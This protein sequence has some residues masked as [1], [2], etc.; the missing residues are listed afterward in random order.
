M[1]D[2]E[3]GTVMGNNQAATT[4]PGEFMGAVNAYTP[5]SLA[6]WGSSVWHRWTAPSTGDWKFSVDRRGLAVSVF[7]GESVEDARLV[8]GAPATRFPDSALFPATRGVEYYI[9]VA[10][11]SAYFS[12]TEF[13][14]SWE[15]GERQEPGNDDFAA[16]MA[17]GGNNALTSLDFNTLTVEHGEPAGS[18]VRTAW[19]TWRPQAGGRHTWNVGRPPGFVQPLGGATLQLSVFR[20]T[21]LAALE[22]VAVDVG[23]DAEMRMAFDAE[24]DTSYA[25]ALGLPR[26]SAHASVNPV[27]LFMEFGETPANDDLASAIALMGM[28]GSV[29]GSNQFATNEPGEFTGALGDSSLW[30]TIEPAQDGWIRFVVEGL[31]GHK[32]AIYTMGAHGNL[33]LVDTSR[34]L[35]FGQTSVNLNAEAGIRYVIRLG[36]Y[37][38]DADGPGGRGRGEFVLSWGPGGP[39]ARLAFVEVVADAGTG[40]DGSEIALLGLGSQAFNT[41][42]TELYVASALGIVVFERDTATGEL[43]PM[44]TLEDYPIENPT[45]QLVWDEAGAALLVASCDGWMRFTA[46]EGGGIEAA[47]EVAGGPCP[48]E[49]LLIDGSFVHNVMRNVMIETYRFD[50]ERTALESV[51]QVMIDGVSSVAM[52]A[53]GSHVYAI[54][55]GFFDSSLLTFERDADTGSLTMVSTVMQGDPVGDDGTVDGLVNVYGL[56]VHSS[57]LFVA[58]G[59]SGADTAAFDLDDPGNPAFVGKVDSFTGFL[60]FFSNCGF[61]V[62]RHDVAAVDTAC[63]SSSSAYTVQASTDSVFPGDY[64]RMLGFTTDA[65][66]NEV[67]SNDDV[68]SLIESPDGRHL[69]IAGY[70]YYFQFFPVFTIVEQYQVVVF[71]RR[72]G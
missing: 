62:A 24:P 14:L 2:G 58:S 59:R 50:D 38:Y 1:I 66:G 42:G 8:S 22:P 10:S 23:E 69:Y 29:S 49:A 68:F 51:E 55:G 57:H 31:P 37:I 60:S 52:A 47:G 25:L 39:P 70:T 9:G 27:D 11:A 67:P 40:D 20:G 71:E 53:D 43:T 45:T 26:D 30:W 3:T 5:F 15:P 28:S 12:G 56:A 17:L 7:A 6:S 4:E 32:L 65:F 16:A 33:E 13:T 44:Q 18:G 48:T 64:L 36:S 34:S 63:S 46:A 21:E 35:V 54:A 72:S 19:Y 61:G 41:D